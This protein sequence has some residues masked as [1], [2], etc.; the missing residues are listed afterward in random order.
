MVEDINKTIHTIASL[1]FYGVGVAQYIRRNWR[2]LN[3]KTI[4][5]IKRVFY[6]QL[7]WYLNPKA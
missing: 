1:G 5:D 7:E 6:K 4:E 3:L 2:R